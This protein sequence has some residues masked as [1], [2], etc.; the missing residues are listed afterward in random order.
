[1]GCSNSSGKASP[2]APT[3]G[4]KP[5][6]TNG[7]LK[8][9][10]NGAKTSGNHDRPIF[11]KY[12]IFMGKEDVMGKGSSSICRRGKDITTGK[13][14]AIKVYK[15]QSSGGKVKTTTMQKYK[16]QISVLKELM[17]PFK[18]PD[19]GTLWAP[20]LATMKP[21]QI[22]MQLLDYSKDA[23]GEPAPD[24]E[25]GML[26]VV[27]EL[28]Q[29]SLKD[30]IADRREKQ[31]S[32]SKEAV[33]DLSKRI[34][35]AMAGLH[36]KGFVHV[37]MKP[38]NLMVFDGRLKVIDVDGC[39]RI[40]TKVSIND[41]SI[42][43]SPCYCAP[44]WA[45]FII[46]DSESTIVASPSLDVWSVGMTLCEFITLDAIWKVQYA[47][48]MRNAQSQREAGFL[49]LEWLGDIKWAPLPRA[50]EKFDPALLDLLHEWLLVCDPKKRKSCAQALSNP[51]LAEGGWEKYGDSNKP[52]VE[53]A[54]TKIERV[55]RHEDDTDIAT[56]AP[57]FKG[58]LWKHSSNTSTKD[59]QNW[60]RRDM[61]LSRNS[62]LC[63][64]SQKENKRLVLIDAAK[65][66]K[67][68]VKD[69]NGHAKANAFELSSKSD[70]E[71][72][73]EKV[74]LAAD[75]PEDKVTWREKLEQAATMDVDQKF[76]LGE[77]MADDVAA[78][79]LA[80]RNRRIKVDGNTDGFEPTFKGTLWKLKS[81]G[82]RSQPDHWFERTMWIA[83]NGSLVYHS[84][85]EERSLV[86]Y[87]ASD[88]ATAKIRTIDEGNA[89][90]PNIFTVQLQAKD[91]VEFEPGE[92]SVET[93][94]MRGK[95]IELLSHACGP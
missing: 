27:T 52:A 25:D 75:S 86:Y 33:R 14:V 74:L 82:D 49:F 30:F 72:Q 7:S 23:N 51:Y 31:K 40:G 37:D 80:V 92:F 1:M 91:G 66:S 95:W 6:A 50:V 41:G 21:S 13:L 42:S 78:F 67:I 18:E 5:A 73:I 56:Q 58:T 47:S 24:P 22:F 43:F 26:Y 57:I 35:L 32:L 85:K 8:A 65:M 76:I 69:S 12:K 59:Q 77:Q 64:Y 68:Q 63:Y 94:A 2:Q 79:K 45:R 16:R 83:K 61:W 81:G 88:I 15:E 9:G 17:E 71:E 29:Y 3:A 87:T 54:P 28:A 11:G 84:P 34:M 90:K 55:A 46:K 89:C 70:E 53:A 93:T 48:F 20:Q 38:E 10:G 36:A 44:E 60:I 39:V 62:S 4:N 19:D